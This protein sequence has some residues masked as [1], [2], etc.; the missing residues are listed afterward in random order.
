MVGEEPTPTAALVAAGRRLA[1]L[2]RCRGER[3]TPAGPTGGS[4]IE[5]KPVQNSTKR[6]H[7][8][9]K[10]L[11]EPNGHPNALDNIGPSAQTNIQHNIQL[12]G[13]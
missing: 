11:P 3:V 9:R 5:K 8:S 7:G 12:V 2:E 4:N 6:K 1:C 13:G 10:V